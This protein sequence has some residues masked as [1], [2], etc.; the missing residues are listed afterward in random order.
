[1]IVRLDITLT[2]S[3]VGRLVRYLRALIG[4]RR[5]SL[6]SILSSSWTELGSIVLRHPRF[7]L[8]AVFDRLGWT[9]WPYRFNSSPALTFLETWL[10]LVLRLRLC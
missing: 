5:I 9:R 7:M 10:K 8:V 6:G 3:S 2:S 1:M 4:L